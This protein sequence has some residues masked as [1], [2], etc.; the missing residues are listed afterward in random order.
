MRIAHTAGTLFLIGLFLVGIFPVAVQAETAEEKKARLEAELEI[1]E[2]KIT[3][4]EMLVEGKQEERQSLERDLDIIDAQIYKAQL[5]IQARSVAIEQ[6]SDQIDDKEVLITE[7]D[8]RLVKQRQ[9]LAELIRKTSEVDDYSLAE[10]LLSKQSFSNFFEDLESYQSIKESLNESVD[11]LKEIIEDT[12]EQKN[13]LETKVQTEAELK[14]IQES[15]KQQIEVREA[16]KEEILT[17]TKGE[18]AAYQ[19]LLDSQRKTAAQLRNALFQLSGG[20]GAIP[21]PDAVALAKSA[22]TASGVDPA[23]ILAILEQESY[24]GTNIGSCTMGDV[25]AGRDIM[26]PTRDKPVFLAMAP[27]VGFDAATQAV[28]CPLRRADGSR[29]GW[30]GA[31]GASQF[32]PSTWAIY[33]GF[34]QV[35]GT[36]TYNKSDD[37]I[38]SRLGNSRPSSPFNNLDAFT[39]TSLLLRDNGAAG[40][41]ST[42]RLAALRYYAG[43]GGAKNPANFFYGDQVME[44]KARLTSEIRILGGN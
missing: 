13:S 42:D 25:S 1:V 11:T 34:S 27:V 26:H 4:Q 36:W 23:L 21:F 32:I 2:R 3:I 39:A 15:E 35:G 18:E 24:Y 30:G 7:L 14:L 33:G 19:Q 17:V 20:G 29:I 12:G 41:Y 31:M 16:A 37:V 28:S 22:G 43:W 6:L 10:V 40:T 44:R 9:S 38:R 5:G 8:R